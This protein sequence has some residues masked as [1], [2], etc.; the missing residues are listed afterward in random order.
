MLGMSATPAFAQEAKYPPAAGSDVAGVTDATA[1]A[2]QPITADTGT[3]FC[4]AG[5]AVTVAVTG[6]DITGQTTADADGR[7]EFTFDAPSQPGAYEVVF[8]CADGSDVAVSFTVESPATGGAV[9]DTG[10]G[11]GGALPR[12]GSDS[13]VPLTLTGL[14]LVG[15]GGGII[16]AARRRRQDMPGGL[17]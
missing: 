5:S 11:G 12:T 8:T 17:A 9:P 16:V 13:I 10:N 4:P 3:G 7:S 6:T 15:V 1:T 2:G 14:G